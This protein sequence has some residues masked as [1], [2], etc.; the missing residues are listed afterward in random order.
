MTYF[1][2]LSLFTPPSQ[3]QN[4]FTSFQSCTQDDLACFRAKRLLSLWEDKF[5]GYLAKT[6]QTKLSREMLKMLLHCW[7]SKILTRNALRYA[8]GYS[9]ICDPKEKLRSQHVPCTHICQRARKSP[10]QP[11]DL[12]PLNNMRLVVPVLPGSVC[13]HIRV[14]P[15][16]ARHGSRH[17]RQVGRWE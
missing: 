10:V 17:I 6:P 9:T 13:V 2:L 1:S 8:T 14:N 3:K 15:G 5:P 16:P 7:G 4:L 12:P 11:R